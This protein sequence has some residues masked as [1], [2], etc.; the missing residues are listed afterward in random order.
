MSLQF[1]IQFRFVPTGE[2]EKFKKYVFFQDLETIDLCAAY[3]KTQREE[4]R[5]E[6]VQYVMFS[7]C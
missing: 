3:R 5:K 7:R 6:K 2:Q 1:R 4:E